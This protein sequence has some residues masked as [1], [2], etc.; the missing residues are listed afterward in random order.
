MQKK[1]VIYRIFVDGEPIIITLEMVNATDPKIM[2]EY[3]RMLWRQEHR[4]RRE[5]RCRDV[6][7]VR[8]TKICSECRQNCSGKPASL[9]A[10]TKAGMV[11]DDPNSVEER[12]NRRL[13]IEAL[14]AAIEALEPIDRQII[15]LLFFRGCTQRE[16]AERLDLSQSSVNR[17]KKRALNTLRELLADYC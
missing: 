9:E 15:D 11:F 1:E 10:L 6:Y 13:L 3:L 8:C 16:A 2:Q 4:E 7:G 5:Y 14:C 12:V 17:H